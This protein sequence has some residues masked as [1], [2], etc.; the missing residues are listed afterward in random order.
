MVIMNPDPLSSR[1]VRSGVT[2]C[3]RKPPADVDCGGLCIASARRRAE[4]R[5]VVVMVAGVGF[6]LRAV[7]PPCGVLW[8]VGDA[9]VGHRLPIQALGGW[10]SARPPC[11]KRSLGWQT[12]LS[13]LPGAVAT[14]GDS[15]LWGRLQGD[16]PADPPPPPPH[17]VGLD[18]ALR[19][20]LQGS[21]NPSQVRFCRW[22][23][24]HFWVS[25]LRRFSS[26]TRDME[27]I[28]SRFESEANTSDYS[29]L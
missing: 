15:P 7:Q 26:S 21:F 28:C 24:A 27:P 2:C 10:L 17:T 6:F 16:R 1:W 11:F 29:R 20:H 4:Q 3:R 25:P 9:R 12:T 22:G 19:T 8:R 23:R 14:I 13:S 18:A 5:L